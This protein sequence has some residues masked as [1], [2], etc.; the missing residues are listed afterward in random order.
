M[1]FVFTLFTERLFSFRAPVLVVAFLPAA[2]TGRF[3]FVLSV[4][5]GFLG[6]G[7]VF[8][9]IVGQPGLVLPY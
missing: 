8:I 4:Y 6:L 3:V 2:P 5:C 1:P 9:L 7:T